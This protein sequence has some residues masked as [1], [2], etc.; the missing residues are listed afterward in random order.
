MTLEQVFPGLNNAPASAI[1]AVGNNLFDIRGPADE[2]QSALLDNLSREIIAQIKTVDPKWHYDSLGPPNSVAGRINQLNDLRF[3][4]AAV[5]A[6]VKGDYRPLQV[7][8]V[9]FIQQ[10]ADVGFEKGEA[11]L[12]AGLIRPRLSDREA[13][14]NYVD[15]YVRIELRKRY[16]SLGI[17]SAGKGPV[18]VNRR[19]DDSS[20]TDL[21]YRRPDA[22]IGDVAFDVTLSLKTSATKQVQ[23]FFASDFKPVS[24]VIIRPRQVSPDSAYVISRPEIKR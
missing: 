4:R 12:K 20:G 13:I 17:D 5:I 1:L 15:R 11:A 14:G 22:R 10:K 6:R 19:E 23:G 24:V 8:T 21:T 9:R 18:R 7:E 16:N 3:E 2:A